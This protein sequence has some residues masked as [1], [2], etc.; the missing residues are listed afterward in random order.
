MVSIS[1][2]VFASPVPSYSYTFLFQVFMPYWMMQKLLLTE[3]E[4]VELRSIG[5]PPPGSFVR[6]R[7][8]DDEF[9]VLAAQHV[10]YHLTQAAPA[11]EVLPEGLAPLVD[12]RK[13]AFP[14]IPSCTRL[15]LRGQK[16]AY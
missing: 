11:V 2:P 7:P 12:L 8:Q 15:D 13:T 16:R 10:S 14:S 1:S 6:F 4:R 3:G 5:R 9:L